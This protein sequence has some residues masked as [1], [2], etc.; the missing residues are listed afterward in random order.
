MSTHEQF[1]PMTQQAEREIKQRLFDSY[2]Q[3]NLLLMRELDE[4]PTHQ[5]IENIHA[6]MMYTLGNAAKEKIMDNPHGLDEKEDRA[7]LSV[8]RACQ[9]LTRQYQNN[10]PLGRNMQN[11]ALLANAAE[12]L[13]RQAPQYYPAIYGTEKQW[14]ADVDHIIAHETA[15]FMKAQELQWGAFAHIRLLLTPDGLFGC[16]PGITVFPKSYLSPEEF[17]VQRNEIILA[18]GDDLSMGDIEILE[19]LAPHPF[20]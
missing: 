19:Q 12:L 10:I 20:V 8:Q 16:Q 17:L 9:V 3:W 1:N 6:G 5:F 13:L 15:H 2:L 7:L 14:S 11:F 18:V 4:K